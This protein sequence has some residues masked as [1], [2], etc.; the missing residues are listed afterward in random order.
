MVFELL[1]VHTTK[2]GHCKAVVLSS[3]VLLLVLMP[4]SIPLYNE[5]AVY[6]KLRICSLCGSVKGAEWPLFAYLKLLPRCML[7]HTILCSLCKW[8][9]LTY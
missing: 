9:S 5:C 1:Q 2:T 3:C 8:S 4:V 7:S 6:F